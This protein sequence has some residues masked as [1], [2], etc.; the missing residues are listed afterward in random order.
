MNKGIKLFAAG[1][2]IGAFIALL[3]AP[4]S[5]K[6]TRKK[7]RKSAGRIAGRVEK[8]SEGIYTRVSDFTEEA[9]HAISGAMHTA[10]QGID[11]VT[12]FGR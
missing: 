11:K 1:A 2:G 10:K 5:G 6:D 3:T 9:G 7:L 8:V 4:A 12:S